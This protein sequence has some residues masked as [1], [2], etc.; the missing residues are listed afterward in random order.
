MGQLIDV[1]PN[2]MSNDPGENAWWRDV[3]EN[4]PSSPF[5]RFFDI[6]WDPIKPELRDKLL[7]PILRNQYGEALE[8]GELRL[9]YHDG[10]LALEYVDTRLPI[11]PRQA[12]RLFEHDLERLRAR[13]GEDDPQLREFLSILTALRNLP[14]YTERDAQRIAERHREEQIARE[15]LARLTGQSPAVL[16]HIA[17]ALAAFNGATADPASFD[18]LHEL[19]EV[20]AYRLASWRTAFDEINYRRFFNI[21]ELS[22]LR[23]EDPEVFARTHELVLRLVREGKVGGFRID[24]VDGLFDPQVYL[25][26]LQAEAGGDGVY[27]VVEKIL[28]PGEKLP[29]GWATHGTTGYDFLNDVAGIFV[30]RQHRSALKRMYDRF[31]GRTE[32][33]ADIAYES[34]RLIELTS[35]V[36][37]LTVLANSL[38]RI[39]ERNRRSRDFTLESCRRALLE[40][41]ACFPVYR[42]YVGPSGASPSDRETIDSAIDD[43]RRRN[44]AME[45]S[46]FEF[47]RSVLVPD[48]A[49]CS[50]AGDPNDVERRTFPMRFQQ[51][52]APVQAKGIEDT[53][54]YRYNVLVSLNEVGGSPERFG[55][56]VAEFHEANAR[57]LADQPL[58]MISTSTHDTKRG[59]DVRARIS[60]ISEIP[61][62]WRRAVSQWSR[63]NAPNKTLVEGASAP[64]RNDEYL[65]YQTLAGIWPPGVTDRR[66]IPPDVVDRIGR[67][68]TKATKE[69]KLHTSWISANTAYDD[70][71][72]SFVR[73]TLDG[74]RTPRFLASFVPSI[75]TTASSWTTQ[76]AGRCWPR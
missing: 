37:E 39:S 41:I 24:H 56:S 58:G 50:G 5:A 9:A 4:G 15:R 51:Y 23:M 42:T 46:I 68:M 57:R 19:L 61:D 29:Q 2:H 69:A 35:M 33:F 16:E 1:V 52:T 66:G 7:L 64:D 22:G 67:Y 59:E 10:A 48:A 26:R 3:L 76:A 54:F 13:L 28:A 60:A 30:D 43:A 14:P 36:S 71:V 6:D 65:F 53:A 17:A 18:R 40:V 25:A 73:E 47:V 38:N 75:P 45:R 11:N 72:R 74:A 55:R 12:P 20:Q 49:P 63:I 8:A 32:P 62:R 70:A 31:T 34:K 44:P 21:N 27:V